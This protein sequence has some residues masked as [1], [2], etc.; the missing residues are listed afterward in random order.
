MAQFSWPGH[1]E[2]RINQGK[3]T[4]K[5]VVNDRREGKLRPLLNNLSLNQ[6]GGFYAVVIVILLV[7]VD[8]TKLV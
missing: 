4:E 6:L 5:K 2:G 7:F 3:C 1:L 8:A